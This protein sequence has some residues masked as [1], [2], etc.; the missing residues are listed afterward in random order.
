MSQS[1]A[2]VEREVEIIAVGDAGV[3]LR[4]LSNCSDCSGCGGRCNVFSRISATGTSVL[5]LAA[6]GG[7][8]CVGER[9]RLQL[10]AQALLRQSLRLYGAALA[11]L[12]LG[13]L[14]GQAIAAWLPYP[15]DL[16]AAGG[17]LLGTLGALR[18]S[19]RKSDVRALPASG[20]SAAVVDVPRR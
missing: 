18:L 11:G 4:A 2:V 16:V 13:A 19:N 20:P 1:P 5:P 7:Q 10:P 9:W 14:V 17:A 6:F 8:P 15:S 3:S 12:L